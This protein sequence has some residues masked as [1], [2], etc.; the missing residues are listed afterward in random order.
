M[1]WA[2]P[3]SLLV[4]S[5]TE[6]GTTLVWQPPEALGASFVEYDTLRSPSASDFETPA[7]CADTNDVDTTTVDLDTPVAGVVFHYL[8]RVD[9]FC[10]GPGSMG[11]G[12]DLQPRT[13]RSCP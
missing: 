3:A 7:V 2:E 1:L 13:G 4:L 9:N 10:P 8:I 5:S 6:V 11:A 12:S